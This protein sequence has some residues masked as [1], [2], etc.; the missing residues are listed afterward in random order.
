MLALLFKV[1]PGRHEGG[2]HGLELLAVVAVLEVEQLVDD[3]V[4]L[5]VLGLGG[6]VVGQRHHAVRRARAPFARQVL[7]LELLRVDLELNGP[8]HG[9]PTKLLLGVE[10]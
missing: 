10:R 4:V 7:D 3:D 6:K 5:E 1:P 8:A 9:A 2:H